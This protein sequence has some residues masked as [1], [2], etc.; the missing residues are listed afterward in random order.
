LVKA[1]NIMKPALPPPP[2]GKSGWPWTS[3]DVAAAP[4]PPAGGWPRISLITPSFNQGHYLEETIRS[5]LHQDYPHLE[6]FIIDGGSRDNS[7]DVIR[8]YEPW[9]TGWVSE[10][11]RGQPHALMKG[12]ARCSGEW[13]NWINSDDYLAPGTLFRV[14][15]TGADA[16]AVGGACE[17]FDDAGHRTVLYNRDVKAADLIYGNIGPKFHQPSLWLRREK[18]MACGAIDESLN[19][20]FD[21]DLTV[22][23]LANAPR[24]VYVDDVLSH[25]RL[26]PQSKTCSQGNRF[27]ADHIASCHK[28]LADP[29]YAPLH[30]RARLGLRLFTWFAYLEGVQSDRGATRIGRAA[31]VAAAS[32]GDLRVRGSR[33]TLGAIRRLL[34]AG[35]AG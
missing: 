19:F 22:R 18:V 21:W 3:S 2:A 30:D 27:V 9:V 1:S 33:Y 8:K 4:P 17:H 23:F 32:L 7:V 14:A 20:A 16:D 10:K 25:F 13:F 28:L 34:L 29:A 12:L 24:V 31:K 35:P 5:V 15:A 6:Y 26:Q 11:D